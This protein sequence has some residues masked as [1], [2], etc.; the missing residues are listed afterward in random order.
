MYAEE[1]DLEGH[2]IDSF[3]LQKVLDDIIALGG[4]FRIHEIHI[5]PQRTD[6]SHA[7]IEITAPDRR[8][9]DEILHTV[10]RHGALV[11]TGV[12][13]QLVAADMNGAFPTEFYATTNQQTFVRHQGEWHEVRDQEM[14]CGLTY[15]P[16]DG[17]F[18]C[19]PVANV[20]QGDLIVC[21]QRGVKVVAHAQARHKGGFEFMSSDI[22]TEK[23][24]NTL[25]RNCA[26][27]MVEC[28]R[29][30]RKLL[31][32]AGPAIVHTGAGA[33]VVQLIERGYF[34]VLFA[35]NALAT[36][37]IEQHLYG[38]SLGIYLD[39]AS[40]ADGG[41]EH[42]LRSINAI[43]RAGSIRAA[44][45]SGKLTGGIMHACVKHAVHM[46][47]AGSLRDDGPL[48]DVVTDMLV[49]Q[50][51]MRAAIRD[52]GFVLMVATALHSI[53][54]GNI[55]P[56]WIPA[57]CID[58]QPSILTKLADRG[59]AQTIGVVTD[60]EPFFRELIHEID[61]AERT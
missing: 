51:Q 7:R 24:K 47:L 17:T 28:R 33:L 21:G 32:V 61:A 48:P 42:H 1:I 19:L 53:A 2:F 4:D 46:V 52:V 12:D 18:H 60:V 25:I 49:A 26:R 55:L 30:R 23:P 31:L 22:S 50:D 39:R 58:I 37:D 43:R 5:G 10:A 14:D 45:E 34:N 54:T 36:H 9:L 44:V 35:G 13:V 20:R 8:Q 27:L 59:S 16:A 15:R 3:M 38:T 11:R 57:V 56:A 41:H 6:R 29:T 40:P